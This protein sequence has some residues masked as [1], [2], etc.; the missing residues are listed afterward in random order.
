[1]SAGPRRTEAGRLR[2]R[3]RTALAAAA[4][5][6][7]LA[8]VILGCAVNQSPSPYADPA[9]P[10]HTATGFRNNYLEVPE[11]SLWELVRWRLFAARAEEPA[12]GW[13]IPVVRPDAAWLAANRIEPS[14]T[15]IGHSTFLL[16]L[17]GLNILTDPQLSERASPLSWIG[18]RRHAAPALAAGTLPHIDLVLISHNHFDHLDLATVRALDAQPGGPPRFV[19]PLG[20]GRWL[21]GEGIAGATELDWWERSDLGALRVHLVPAQHWST[22]TRFDRNETLWGGFVIEAPGR[23][24]FFAGDTG[25]SPDFADIGRRFGGFDL[26]L[27]PIGAY[28]P[29][30]FM[31]P[32]HVDPDEAVKIHRDLGARVSAGMHWGT[33]RLTDEPLDE[34][35]R[36][37][38]AARV[39]AG[40]EEKDFFAMAIGETRLL[41]ALD[42]PRPPPAAAAAVQ[43]GLPAPQERRVA[44]R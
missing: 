17:A 14:L 26:A 11:H 2:L 24:V 35:P 38:A 33:F 3:P 42:R 18:P 44:G 37:L 4:A 34:P 21:A 30:W 41:D 32:Q 12:G 16:Q 39:R 23:R 29:R 43:D 8:G 19:V 40:L 22:R 9:R 25:Y 1:V 13:T 31:Q 6:I 28:Q 27:I 36:Q 5:V 20:I 10:W 15:W 7:A